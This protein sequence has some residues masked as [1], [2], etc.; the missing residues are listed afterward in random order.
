M[1]EHEHSGNGAHGNHRPGLGERVDHIGSSAQ[2][3]FT[4]ARDGLADLK[5]ML[6]IQGRMERHPYAMLTA[7]AAVGYVLGGGLVTSLTG[8][9]LRVALKVAAMPFIKDELVNIAQNTLS[10]FS[11]RASEPN[12]SSETSSASGASGI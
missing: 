9:L 2:Q 10:G 5:Q 11:A 7:A 8:R 6:D 4:E 3:M 12:P 1:S